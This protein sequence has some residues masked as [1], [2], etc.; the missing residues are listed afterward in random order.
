MSPEG[1]DEVQ[2]EA[3]SG[4]RPQ[5]RNDEPGQQPQCA[6]PSNVPIG[7]IQEWG[8]PILSAWLFG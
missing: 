7:R 3:G 5:Y 8:T 1:A 4:E 6:C 2:H